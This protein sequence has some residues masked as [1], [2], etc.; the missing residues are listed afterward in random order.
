MK[1]LAKR[2]YSGILYVLLM[3]YMTLS[4]LWFSPFSFLGLVSIYEMLKVRNGKSKFFALLFVI[5]PFI[6]IY[7][8][9]DMYNLVKYFYF[10]PLNLTVFQKFQ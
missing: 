2:T 9:I 7:F 10:S 5:C 6:F 1:N 4:K 8:I 3:W